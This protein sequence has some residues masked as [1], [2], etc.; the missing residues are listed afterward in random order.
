MSEPWS[1]GYCGPILEAN[2]FQPIPISRPRPGDSNLGKRP[3]TTL[4]EWQRPACVALRLPQY[5]GCGTG[6]LTATT[7]AVDIDVRAVEVAD[8]IDRGVR[9]VLGEAPTRYGQAPKRVLVYRAAEPFSKLSTAG[10]RLPGDDTDAKAHKVE[11]LGDG[12]QFVAYGI[13]P[14]TGRPYAWPDDDLLN[15]ERD[16]LAPLTQELAARVVAGAE[17]VLAKAGTRIGTG[18]RPAKPAR[19][20]QPGPQPRPVQDRDEAKLVLDTLQGIDPSVLDYDAWIRVGYAI[21]AALGEHGE[22][23]WLAWSRA[24]SRHDGTF[25]ERGTPERAWRGINPQRCGWRY[26]QRLHGQITAE[27]LTNGR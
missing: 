10:F 25:G 8:A 2:G 18:T 1:F 22:C 19:D 7:P 26:I 16:D 5:A 21:K 15:L 14:A 23:A 12:Q 4:N 27:G 6:I 17:A 3:P 13:H 9:K 24:S 20:R 11:I